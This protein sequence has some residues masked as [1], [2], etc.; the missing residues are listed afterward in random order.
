MNVPRPSY[1]NY[2]CLVPPVVQQVNNNH[3]S[4]M[5]T[6]MN[7]G[8]EDMGSIAVTG[9]GHG[10][11]AQEF[12]SGHRAELDWQTLFLLGNSTDNRVE[13][14]DILAFGQD[15][16]Y[17]A[18][19]SLFDL[20]LSDISPSTFDTLFAPQESFLSSMGNSMNE[21][22]HA[23]S[24]NF[25]HCKTFPQMP[26]LEIRVLTYWKVADSGAVRPNLHHERNLFHPYLSA[27]RQS[28][29][30]TPAQSTSLNDPAQV[31]T[32]MS[33]PLLN[34]Y[35][36]PSSEDL[37]ARQ[38]TPVATKGPE[39]TTSAHNFEE[40]CEIN[41][42]KRL[43]ATYHL[44]PPGTERAQTARTYF[45]WASTRNFAKESVGYVGGLDL[46]R[47]KIRYSDGNGKVETLETVL[48]HRLGWN[49]ATFKAST[50]VFEAVEYLAPNFIWNPEHVP[51]IS[52]NT[53][54]TTGQIILDKQSPHE[55]W[56]GIQYLFHVPGYFING[57]MP[58]NS[59]LK[60]EKEQIAAQISVK[61]MQR[62]LTLIRSMLI[63]LNDSN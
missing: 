4:T 2:G 34:G 23:H 11:E 26:L 30:L 50:R 43:E 5:V 56:K 20:P 36:A 10:V 21:A 60:S 15:H 44:R 3:S 13:G 12:L 59:I 48:I 63:P 46:Q 58:L 18:P 31:V 19:V 28:N 38:D 57:K 49:I 29:S 17:Q 14:S 47:Y 27:S 40:F 54:N 33:L 51:T 52:T 55:V 53:R 39:V 9:Q 25:A 8:S 37:H 22:L 32:S 24:G 1:E 16:Q 62:K 6:P 45:Q 42:Y 61:D 7:I 41:G 35:V